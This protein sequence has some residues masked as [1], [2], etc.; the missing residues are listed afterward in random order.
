[1][2][3]FSS[4]NS[5]RWRRKATERPSLLCKWKLQHDQV[6]F[7]Y[8]AV[9]TPSASI[10]LAARDDRSSVTPWIDP[11]NGDKL[12]CRFGRASKKICGH[13]RVSKGL[14]VTALRS[15]FGWD[16][17]KLTVGQGR[18]RTVL[19]WPSYKKDLQCWTCVSFKCLLDLPTCSRTDKDSD[20]RGHG[21]LFFFCKRKAK[22]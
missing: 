19:P 16:E 8:D 3:W 10:W 21:N 11:L 7:M 20:S 17:L 13:S 18:Q 9:R 4:K 12:A 1:M 6:A 2:A 14:A 5:S 22:R 15:S